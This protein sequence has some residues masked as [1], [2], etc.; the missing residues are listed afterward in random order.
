MALNDESN[1]ALT[2]LLRQRLQII[3]DHSWR[4]ANPEMHLQALREVSES[5]DQ[6]RETLHSALPPRLRH[7]LEQ[8]SYQKALDYLEETSESK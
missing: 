2:D 3:A 1:K 7:F 6:L 4:D 5:I 8:S